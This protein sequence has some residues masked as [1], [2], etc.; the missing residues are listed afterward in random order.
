MDMRSGRHDAV[1]TH[2]SQDYIGLAAGANPEI[3]K[4]RKASNN[5]GGQNVIWVADAGPL[6][7]PR[8]S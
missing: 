3:L 1:I 6:T 4:G 7:A 8:W 2:S 5:D